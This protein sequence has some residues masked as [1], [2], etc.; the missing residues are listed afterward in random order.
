MSAML[1][2]TNFYEPHGLQCFAYRV[3][4]FVVCVRE[5]PKVD[6]GNATQTL[7]WLVV[8]AQHVDAMFEASTV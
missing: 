2:V 8:H 3:C 5:V 7:P 1:L 4:L 6:L